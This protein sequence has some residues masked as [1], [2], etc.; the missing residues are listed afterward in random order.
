MSS[1][2][3]SVKP[4]VVES[5]GGL[6]I[7][8]IWVWV[9]VTLHIADEALNGFL[10]IYNPTVLALR[11]KL[12]WWPMP[13]FTF[14]IWLASLITG[15]GILAALTPFAFRNSGWLRPIIYFCAIVFCIGNALGHTL[16]TILGRTVSTVHFSR[17]A[18][19]FISSPILLFAGVYALVQ[20]RRTRKELPC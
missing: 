8:W 3:L 18:P 19:G 14:E 4:R 7:A 17:P 15:V 5:Y 12:G 11:E 16:A 10:Y 13:T 9:A 6:G 2:T 1:A 20:L